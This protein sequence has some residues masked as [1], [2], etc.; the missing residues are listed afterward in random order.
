[1]VTVV[2]KR[3]CRHKWDLSHQHVPVVSMFFR[4]SVEGNDQWY[5][6]DENQCVGRITCRGCRWLWS[7]R[8]RQ[9]YRDRVGEQRT[10]IKGQTWPGEELKVVDSLWDIVGCVV[11]SLSSVESWSGYQSWRVWNEVPKRPCDEHVRRPVMWDI[12]GC[13]EYDTGVRREWRE[14]PSKRTLPHVSDVC[15]PKFQI[16]RKFR[17]VGGSGV[18]LEV[19]N[20]K[21]LV[22]LC[23]TVTLMT[24]RVLCGD[25]GTEGCD[26]L[27]VPGRYCTPSRVTVVPGPGRRV[28]QDRHKTSER[29]GPGDVV[30]GPSFSTM[31]LSI[32]VDKSRSKGEN[33]NMGDG[34]LVRY[35][36]M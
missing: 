25:V 11:L 17:C 16:V 32:V 29:R 4:W 9:P 1:M 14:V 2:S 5:F 27:L 8:C 15:R 36:M 23:V 31:F 13:E 19:Y 18:D 6:R 22:S 12:I 20:G 35:N 3:T 24:Y 26:T 10:T 33:I 34:V 28:N 7:Q 21:G 30:V